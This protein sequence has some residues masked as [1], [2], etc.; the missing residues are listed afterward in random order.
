MTEMQESI[1]DEIIIAQEAPAPAEPDIEVIEPDEKQ[2]TPPVQEQKAKPFDPKTDK[3][4]FTTPEQQ[5]KFDYLYKQVKM[6]DARNQMLN[7]M[8]Q[9]AIKR[10]E[11][12]ENRFKQTDSAEAERI[13]MNKIKSAR[14]IG[15]DASEFAAT[16]ELAEFIADKKIA[17]RGFQ[18]QQQQL[19]P[20]TNV[21]PEDVKYTEDFMFAQDDSGNLIRPWI[22]DGHQDQVEAIQFLEQAKQKYIGDP[23]ALP[24][25]L[26]ELDNY[27]KG[28]TMTTQ[29]KPPAAQANT[30]A[31]S[32]LQG[33]N[34]TNVQGQVKIKM[35]RQEL[36][37]AKKLGVDPKKY[38]ARR[39]AIASK[40]K[41]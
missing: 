34:L 29:Q 37:V 17:E 35:T 7:D 20:Q 24:K 27:M 12:L 30:R 6:S 9:T 19:Q 40:G 8:N 11:E 39:D 4:E 28:K 2:E 32:P 26:A 36:E 31:P 18:V 1:Q 15:D 10:L 33:S 41:R 5:Q 23:Y 3:V 25:T 16:K 38:A 21:R 13:L 22:Q 14:N